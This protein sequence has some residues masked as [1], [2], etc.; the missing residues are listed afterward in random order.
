MFPKRGA[1]TLVATTLA[2]IL[3][4]S[5]KTPDAVTLGTVSTTGSSNGTKANPTLGSAS[6]S[7]PSSN[8][9]VIATPAPTTATR[10]AT[11]ASSPT[12]ATPAP[13]TTT[14]GPATVTGNVVSTRYGQVEVRI[15]VDNGKITDVQALRL[16]TNGNSG[17]ISDYVKPIL[18][19][20]AL[21]AQSANIDIVSGATYTSMGYAKSLQSALDQAGIAALTKSVSG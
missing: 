7:R 16:P 1:I 14:A 13:T 19:S 6:I 20:E 21:Q 3:L 9:A 2:V 15:T 8:A 4:I 5:F 10:P 18:A 12:A 17:Q 11:G